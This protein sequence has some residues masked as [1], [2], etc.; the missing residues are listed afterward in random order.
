MLLVLFMP[1]SVSAAE[2]QVRT[3][4]VGFFAFDGYHEMM[5]AAG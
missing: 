3:I 5:K 4:K 1:V 2:S